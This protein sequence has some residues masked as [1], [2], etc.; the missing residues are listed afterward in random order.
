MADEE[1]IVLED[2]ALTSSCERARIGRVVVDYALKREMD[3][4]LCLITVLT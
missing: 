1:V 3:L 2:T 4:L